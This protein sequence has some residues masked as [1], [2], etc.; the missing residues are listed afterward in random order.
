LFFKA[1]VKA[2]A[3]IKYEKLCKTKSLSCHACLNPVHPDSCTCNKNAQEF[4]AVIDDLIRFAYR[5]VFERILP[6]V[7]TVCFGIYRCRKQDVMSVTKTA[8]SNQ[9]ECDMKTCMQYVS[10]LLTEDCRNLVHARMYVEPARDAHMHATKWYRRLT[11][12]EGV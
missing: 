10:Q 3:H 5:A 9:I 12:H 4:Q 6:Q 8:R 7:Q 1:H 11:L 2:P